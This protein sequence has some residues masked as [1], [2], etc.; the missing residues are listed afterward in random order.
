M[1]RPA[2]CKLSTLAKYKIQSTKYKI[3]NREGAD[4]QAGGLMQVI[5]VGNVGNVD[6]QVIN[7]DNGKC[8][9]KSNGKGSAKASGG[10]VHNYS[11]VNNCFDNGS[12]TLASAIMIKTT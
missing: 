11:Y 7:I 10:G 3:Q 8:K 2:A 9:G 6:V 5:N 1:K 4:E 12:S